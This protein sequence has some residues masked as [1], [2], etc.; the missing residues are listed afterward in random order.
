MFRSTML[1]PSF[2]S[3]TLPAANACAGTS[4][5]SIAHR[6]RSFFIAVLLSQVNVSAGQHPAVLHDNAGMILRRGESCAIRR[7]FEV[8]GKAWGSASRAGCGT[9]SLAGPPVARKRLACPGA[10]AAGPEPRPAK[11]SAGS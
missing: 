7:D 4:S 5:A 8:V 2:A 11:V 1:L 9:G 6:V 3:T 10:L